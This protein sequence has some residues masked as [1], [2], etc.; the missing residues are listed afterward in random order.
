MVVENGREEAKDQ[1]PVSSMGSLI[2]SLQLSLVDLNHHPFNDM[3]I[4]FL[5]KVQRLCS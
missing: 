2:N 1:P 4:N 3:E 5:Q